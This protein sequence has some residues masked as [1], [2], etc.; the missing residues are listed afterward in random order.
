MGADIQ[1]KGTQITLAQTGLTKRIIKALGLD[2]KW[3]ISCDTPAEKTP[4][5][6]DVDRPL[7]SGILN[8]A[9]TIGMLLYLT[10]HSISIVLLLQ[11]SVHA[12]HLHP[13][14]DMKRL[15]SKLVGTSREH[16]IKA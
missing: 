2:S 1:R 7:A 4:L 13:L 14:E 8:Y 10:G 11:T 16:L 12:T 5:P 3:S 6:Q 9:S 15:S